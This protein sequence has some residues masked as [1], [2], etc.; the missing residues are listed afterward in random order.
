MYDDKA[1]DIEVE[2]SEALRDAG[3]A[4]ES[5]DA[6]NDGAIDLDEAEKLVKEYGLNEDIDSSSKA[7]IDAFFK[8][9]DEDG[10]KSI[11]KAEWLAFYGKLFDD[12]IKNGMQTFHT[13]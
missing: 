8:S 9:F 10:D 3:I 2:R 11:T 6:N 1:V 7:M 4:F 12:I 5:V 13:I